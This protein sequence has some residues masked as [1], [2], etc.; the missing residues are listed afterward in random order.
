MSVRKR[1]LSGGYILAG[2]S[3]IRTDAAF[4]VT[5]NLRPSVKP[6]PFMHR[7]APRSSPVCTHQIAL[8]LRSQK[9]LGCGLPAASGMS[10]NARRSSPIDST[11]TC[12]LCLISAPLRLSRLSAPAVKA[13]RDQLLDAG[14][15]RD[16]VRRVLASLAALVGEAQ[17][18]GLVA[19]NNVRTVARVKR[20]KRTDTSLEMPTRDE[21]RAII[22]ATPERH[23]PLILTGLLVGLRAS[24]L[25]GLLWDDVDLKRGEIHVRRRVDRY[26]PSSGCRSRRPARAQFR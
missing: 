10:S 15:S 22:A 9:P 5:A 12:I 21:L 26:Q 13:F 23:R 24:E 4:A 1:V 7:R 18:R 11:S 14:R 6:T 3:T 16:M 25:R 8:R 19:V 20:G 17:A 2:R